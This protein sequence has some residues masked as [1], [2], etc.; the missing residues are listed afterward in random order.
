MFERP[1]VIDDHRATRTPR[2]RPPIH[3]GRKHEVIDDQLAPPFEQVEQ[4]DFAARPVENVVLF[5]PHHRQPAP[6]RV[7]RIPRL[8]RRLLLDQELVASALPFLAR[9][10]LRQ[11]G[12]GGLSWVSA[13]FIWFP[14]AS[15]V[16]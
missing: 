14:L 2:R 13:D 12:Q 3:A 9:N 1:D 16:T 7:Q 10:N 15:A 8:R 5:D 11:A 4:P 6:F